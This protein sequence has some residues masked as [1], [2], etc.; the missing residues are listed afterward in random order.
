MKHEDDER[1]LP[2]ERIDWSLWRR[3]FGYCLKEK[4]SVAGLACFGV[5]VAATDASFPLVTAGAIDAVD[6]ARKLEVE[7][8]TPF[9]I[10]ET[11]EPWA[12]AYAGLSFALALSVLM[13]V[14]FTSRVRTTVAHDIRADAFERL[15][16]LS[17][18]FFDR[19]SSG[20]LLARTTSDCE[21][22]SN[23][24][25]WGLL[26]V[27]WG[28]A[29]MLGISVA[30]LLLQPLL[31]LGVL[32]F[33]PILWWISLR[34]QR[35]LI[36][37]S[38]AIRGL[39][40]RLTA[41]YTEDLAG[42]Q[43]TNSFVQ[44]GAQHGIFAGL[45]TRMADAS[46][47]NAVQAA[48]YLPAVM[49]VASLATGLALV[50][51]GV[52]VGSGALSIG[53]LIAF[54]T[55]TRQFFE[56]LQELAARFTEAQM[57]QAAAERV[58]GLIDEQPEIVDGPQID[59]SAERDA[60]LGAIQFDQVEF[61]YR[62]GAPVLSDFNLEIQPGET[63]ALVGP[64]GGGKST[65]VSLLCRFY[66]PTAG[67][68]RYD[69]TDHRRRSLA[70]LRRRIAIVLQTPH[71][72][73]GTVA[74]NLR[75]GKLNATDEELWQALEV[76]HAAD[77][78]RELPAGLETQVGEGGARLSTGQ[79]Q[80]L[81]FARALLADPELL[82]MDEATS[83]V[84]TETERVVQRALDQV[85]QGRTSVVIAHR[86]ST[87]R[88]ADRILVIEGGRIVEEGDHHAL[89]A[90]HGRYRELYTGVALTESAQ[91][92]GG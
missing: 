70:W 43:T 61:A 34:F 27:C 8:G 68:I 86:L 57:A 1:E 28:L 17:F 38:R 30:M 67:V 79:K 88:D 35:R 37:T 69:G 9:S 46:V 74:E 18:S 59:R 2:P 47:T 31:A 51:G 3:L 40:S 14:R 58:I 76:V 87:I 11:L 85:L 7:T 16:S 24:L 53:V 23:V 63:I 56:P 55:Y 83:S 15:Q 82:V 78:V 64:T 80:L 66:E 39:N 92:F 13:F 48:L 10:R 5:I 81:S 62:G 77:L 52:Q 6:A 91:H 26:D 45:S 12:W 65:I 72:F 90:Q 44:A 50:L 32:I 89:L 60:V 36:V 4:R 21:R 33:V 49:A 25:A 29:V 84:D 54:L 20:W 22:L 75:Y 19:H 42:V 71:L 73:S 41:S